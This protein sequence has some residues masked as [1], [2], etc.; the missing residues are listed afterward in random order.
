MPDPRPLVR[1]I[2]VTTDHLTAYAA[3]PDALARALGVVL[4]E[5]WPEFPEAFG[6]TLDVLTERPADHAWWMYFFVGERVGALVG[7]G[8]YKGPPV[9]G[10]VEIGYEIGPQWRGRG[11]ATA[12]VAALVQRARSSG[13][14][15]VVTAH[16]LGQ[17]NASV[18]VLRRN[19]FVRSGEVADPEHGVIWSWSLHLGP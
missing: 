6:H 17:E 13:S 2:E 12:A 8:G 1:L 11:Y 18:A 10:G 16:T 3:D 5:G 9:D 14:V 7:S 19:G 15:D 4:P